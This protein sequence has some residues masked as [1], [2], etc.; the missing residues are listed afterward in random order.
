[1]AG[2]G[3]RREIR[4]LRVPGLSLRVASL[5][6]AVRNGFAV[7][8]APAGH[9]SPPEPGRCAPPAPSAVPTGPADAPS[10]AAAPGD[11]PADRAGDGFAGGRSGCGAAGTATGQGSGVMGGGASCGGSGPMTALST[12]EFGTDSMP[13]AV[14]SRT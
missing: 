10:A 12:C 5:L 9:C 6:S 3:T 7:P 1:E 4:M 13:V 14:D 8:A 2:F 11:G